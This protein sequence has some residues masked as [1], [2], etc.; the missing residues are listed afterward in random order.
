[1]AAGAAAVVSAGRAAAVAGAADAEQKQPRPRGL[2]RGF[3]QGGESRRLKS[4]A[5]SGYGATI[6]LQ[7]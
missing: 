2:S 1:A 6:S 3:H 4:R 5:L 7:L